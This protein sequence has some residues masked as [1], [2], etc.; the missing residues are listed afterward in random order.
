MIR[1]LTTDT[2]S[3]YLMEVLFK[4]FFVII[5]EFEQ[6]KLL[7]IYKKLISKFYVLLGSKYGFFFLTTK[8]LLR[9]MNS[10][11]SYFSFISDG[12]RTNKTINMVWNYLTR[13]FFFYKI[14]F[15]RIISL[16]SRTTKYIYIN[17]TF[18]IIMW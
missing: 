12:L 6:S 9:P 14:M 5:C 2:C 1:K 13:F 18:I 7:T 4:F 10:L 17:K 16:F 3:E 8:C 11:N 15:F